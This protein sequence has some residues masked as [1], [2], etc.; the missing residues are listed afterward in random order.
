MSDTINEAIRVRSA[1]EQ[2]VAGIVADL[3]DRR[4][5][6][7]EW[8]SIDDETRASIVSAWVT[9]V[10]EAMDTSANGV[11][12]HG[13]ARDGSVSPEAPVRPWRVVIENG[14]VIDVPVTMHRDG[15][16]SAWHNPVDVDDVSPRLAVMRLATGLGWPVREVIA[17]DDVPASVGTNAQRHARGIA[18]LKARYCDRFHAVYAADGVTL[19]GSTNERDRVRDTVRVELEALGWEW[20]S[21]YESWR[22]HRE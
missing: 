12:A 22:F 11:A 5:L 21:I 18:I 6:K 20:A 7:R 16:F 9:I 4:G 1:A 3:T 10:S 13:Q 17:P 2:A 14:T 15:G 8:G 19:A